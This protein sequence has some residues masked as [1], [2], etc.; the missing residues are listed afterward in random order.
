MNTTNNL[1]YLKY[2]IITLSIVALL[3][4]SHAA[5]MYKWV[6]SEGVVHFSDER[7]EGVDNPQSVRLRDLTRRQTFPQRKPIHPKKQNQQKRRL[8]EH[9]TLSTRSEISLL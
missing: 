4:P 9:L 6:D 8:R 2:L 1:T 3:V 7:P 5:E